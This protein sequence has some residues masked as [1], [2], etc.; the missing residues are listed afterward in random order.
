[1]PRTPKYKVSKKRNDKVLVA[2]YIT[3]AVV[4]L[5]FNTSVSTFAFAARPIHGVLVFGRN[6]A[7]SN[8]GLAAPQRKTVQLKK[9]PPIGLALSLALPV[10]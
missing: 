9:F 7:G 2:L 8:P 10:E 5:A 6:I 1:M 4:Y 3:H